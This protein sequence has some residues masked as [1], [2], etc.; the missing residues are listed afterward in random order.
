MAKALFFFQMAEF[1]FFFYLGIMDYNLTLFKD[2]VRDILLSPQNSNQTSTNNNNSSQDTSNNLTS[3]LA[4][5][6]SLNG[7]LNNGGVY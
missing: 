6:L 2:S 7:E 4:N 1:L 5:N 3:S